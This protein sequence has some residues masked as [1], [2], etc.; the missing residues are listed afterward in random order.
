MENPAF[1]TP[2]EALEHGFQHLTENLADDIIR[3]I[4]ACSPA[5]FERLVVE[6]M[7]RMGYGGSLREAAQIVGK[8]GDDVIDGIIKEAKL[9]LDVIYIQAKRREGT[10]SRPEINK[11]AGALLG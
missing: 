9:G 6:L 10:V 3:K 5:F 7:V 1:S 11:F 4:I 8:S 2:E